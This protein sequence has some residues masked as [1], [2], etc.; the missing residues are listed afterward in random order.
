LENRMRFPLE[1]FEAVR[2]AFAPERPLRCGYPRQTGWKEDG[3]LK[4][5]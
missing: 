5:R 1:V 4:R 3:R 2:A